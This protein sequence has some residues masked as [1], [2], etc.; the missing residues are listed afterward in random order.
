[1]NKKKKPDADIV[2]RTYAYL[3]SKTGLFSASII[4]Y[5]RRFQRFVALP[6]AYFFLVNWKECTASPLRVLSDFIYI[7]FA[8]IFD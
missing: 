8:N 5:I 3:K 6:Y 1:M 7:F 2:D 4:P